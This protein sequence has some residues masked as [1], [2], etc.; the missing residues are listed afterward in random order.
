MSLLPGVSKASDSLTMGRGENPGVSSLLA[1]TIIIEPY[2]TIDAMK[3][4]D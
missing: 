1:K 3:H 4:L 2:W